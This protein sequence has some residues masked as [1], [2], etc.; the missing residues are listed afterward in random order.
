MLLGLMKVFDPDS[1]CNVKKFPALKSIEAVFKVIDNG[2]TF[3]LVEP[4]TICGPVNVTEPVL[5]YDPV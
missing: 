4:V 5:A 2:V 3:P 1:N